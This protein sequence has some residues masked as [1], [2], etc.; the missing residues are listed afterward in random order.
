MEQIE[1]DGLCYLVPILTEATIQASALDESL[2]Q[3]YPEI[4]WRDI[5]DMG[6]RLRHGY[7]SLDLGVVHEVVENGHID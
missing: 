2:D 7:A 3:R 5:R 6:N 1:I 4:P